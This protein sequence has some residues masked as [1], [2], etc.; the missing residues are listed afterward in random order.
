MICPRCSAKTSVLMALASDRCL[1]SHEPNVFVQ[2]RC[3]L[4]HY[5][6]T[7]KVFDGMI[8]QEHYL[9]SDELNPDVRASMN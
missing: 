5:F 8:Y 2:Y 9:T 3:E 7:L 4:G 6:V 1:P